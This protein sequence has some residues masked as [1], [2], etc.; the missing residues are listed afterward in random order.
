[1]TKHCSTL[2]F[3]NDQNG[4]W[5]TDDC[6][7]TVGFKQPVNRSSHPVCYCF[8]STKENI[9]NEITETGH[10]TV[11]E[12]IT[13]RVQADECACEYKDPTGRCCLG[14]VRDVVQEAPQSQ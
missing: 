12:W 1:M 7:V 4:I 11:I 2:Y 8:G 3:S 10:S 5:T 6:R 13:R 9:T 14:E